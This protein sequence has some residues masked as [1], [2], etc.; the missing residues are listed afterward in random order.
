[1]KT[2]GSKSIKNG[3][4]HAW[5]GSVGLGC[6]PPKSRVPLLPRNMNKSF[7]KRFIDWWK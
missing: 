5:V 4:G 6:T 2:D 7:I 3:A 1:M